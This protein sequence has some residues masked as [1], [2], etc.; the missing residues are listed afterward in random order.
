MVKAMTDLRMAGDYQYLSPEGIYSLNRVLHQIEDELEIVKSGGNGDKQHKNVWIVPHLFNKPTRSFHFACVLD[1]AWGLEQNDSADDFKTQLQN[2]LE[3]LKDKTGKTDE[4]NEKG[5]FENACKHLLEGNMYKFARETIQNI[6][7]S[8]EVSQGI[9]EALH[10]LYFSI[11]NHR[12]LYLP[13]ILYRGLEK[14]SRDTTAPLEYFR[15]DPIKG[16]TKDLPNYDVKYAKR[17]RKDLDSVSAIEYSQ[18]AAYGDKVRHAE[19]T[20]SRGTDF[21]IELA[22]LFYLKD[23]IEEISSRAPVIVLPIYDVWVNGKG[24][25]GIWGTLICTFNPDYEGY[26][27]SEDIVKKFAEGEDNL[28][29]LIRHCVRLAD[30][31]FAAGLTTVTNVPIEPPY[32]LVEHFVKSLVHIQDWECVRVYKGVNNK[33]LYCYKHELP[34]NGGKQNL[35]ADF[36]WK[37][38]DAE[39]CNGVCQNSA[40]G[41]ERLEWAC[42]DIFTKKL[43][44]ELGKQEIDAFRGY[45]LVFEYSKTAYVPKHKDKDKDNGEHIA[46]PFEHAI[47]RQ[48]L[49]VLRLLVPKVQARRAALR[50]AVSAIMGRNMSHNIGSHV[51]AR[52]SSEV[53]TD[54]DSAK[55]GHA[56]HRT[57]FLSYLQ[58]RMDLLAEMATSSQVH[59][60]QSLSLVEQVGRLNYRAQQKR[61]KLKRNPGSSRHQGEENGCPTQPDTSGKKCLVCSECPVNITRYEKNGKPILLTYI[62]GK[63]SLLASVELGK[64]EKCEKYSDTQP[65]CCAY[66]YAA[67]MNGM[68]GLRFSCPGGEVG[69]QA[70][71]IILENTIRNSARHGSTDRDLVQLFVTAD[72]NGGSIRLTIIDPGTRLDGDGK[73]NGESKSLPKT[74]NDILRKESLLDGSGLPVPGNWGVR[75]MQICAQYLAGRP[76]PDLESDTK[77]ALKAGIY[78]LPDD[79]HCLKYEINLRKPHNVI[80]VREKENLSGNTEKWG[81][82]EISGDNPELLSRIRGYEFIVVEKALKDRLPPDFDRVAPIRRITCSEGE[83]DEILKIGSPDEILAKLHAH[84]GDLYTKKGKRK[85]HYGTENPIVSVVAWDPGQNDE[86]RIIGE[87]STQFNGRSHHHIQTWLGEP[88]VGFPEKQYSF[89]SNPSKWM[90]VAWLDHAKDDRYLIDTVGNPESPFFGGAGIPCRRGGENAVHPWLSVEPCWSDSPQTQILAAVKKVYE[91]THET[92]QHE[93]VLNE[94]I[95]AAIPRVIVLDERVQSRRKDKIREVSLYKYWPMVGIWTPFK[96]EDYVNEDFDANFLENLSTPCCDLDRPVFSEIQK[97]LE[98]PSPLDHQ[99]N[100]DFLVVHLTVLEKLQ[101]EGNYDDLSSTLNALV[102]NTTAAEAVKVV[103]TGRGVPNHNEP[104]LGS[105]NEKG[106]NTHHNIRLIPISALLEYLVMRPSKLGLMRVLWSA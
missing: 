12:A 4:K 96:R 13:G 59:W 65:P 36:N 100:A 51:L 71:Y 82:V 14:H 58:R 70:L 60:W 38:Y 95:C 17:E 46:K 76:L 37:R 3:E 7:K 50:A 104:N 49:E 101:A 10:L 90:G 40:E 81:I 28:P 47:I 87:D 23:K 55:T 45:R 53:R 39:A 66:G 33:L 64:P 1:N 43:I 102:D 9:L 72:T 79:K 32:D 93:T 61:L 29:R 42:A 80:I 11:R 91:K 54:L 44:P 5:A 31:L 34:S 69:V 6:D 98:R 97:F 27:D 8:T 2:F 30:E 105:G 73:V 21:L 20:T 88:L 85:E 18:S 68:E 67:D 92:E 84:L 62:T 78:A 25:G 89:S 103:V 74:I 48:Q 86:T 63:E 41:C 75:E 106:N 94:L 83:I 56:D 77:P 19:V 16:G 35:S 99:G 26:N 52:Y 24:Y 15:G 57:D 22:K